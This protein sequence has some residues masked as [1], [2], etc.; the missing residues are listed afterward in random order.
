[1]MDVYVRPLYE[2][3]TETCLP[4]YLTT[5]YHILHCILTYLHAL[6]Y[7][8]MYYMDYMPALPACTAYITCIAYDSW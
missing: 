4:S 7:R 3:V 5:P 1:M 2:H 8:C 6:S